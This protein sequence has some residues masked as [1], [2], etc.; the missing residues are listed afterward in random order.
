MN[1]ITNVAGNIMNSNSV[2]QAQDMAN[3][4]QEQ[5]EVRAESK[6]DAVL[7]DESTVNELDLPSP[8]K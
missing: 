6:Q 5:Q 8:M 3:R 7:P 4:V 2:Q 1:Q